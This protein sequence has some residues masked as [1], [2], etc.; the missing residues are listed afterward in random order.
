MHISTTNL[1]VAF[2]A[3]ADIKSSPATIVPESEVTT[4]HDLYKAFY[5]R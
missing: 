4:W 5:A 1:L 2:G 3:D